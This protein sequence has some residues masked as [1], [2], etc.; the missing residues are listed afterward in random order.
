MTAYKKQE[1]DF[2]DRTRKIILQYNDYIKNKDKSEKYEITLMINSFV[3]LLI[4]PHEEWFNQLPNDLISLSDWGI[5]V[6]HINKI[7]NKYDDKKS[8][9][10]VVNHLRNSVSHYNFIAFENINE[11]ISYIQFK[12]Y[13]DKSKTIETFDAKIPV[14]NIIKFL[15]RFSQV[16]IDKMIINKN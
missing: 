4:L 1:H 16:M 9:K 2:I 5:D 7:K 3:G 15:D 10:A 13:T 11:E 14:E 6:T 12:D 8:V